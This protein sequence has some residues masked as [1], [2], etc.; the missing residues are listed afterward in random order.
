MTALQVWLNK[1]KSI[2]VIYHTKKI[3]EKNIP[4]SQKMQKKSS[5]KTQN[6]FIYTSLSFFP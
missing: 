1:G 2:Y 6:P 4:Q 3:K 5:G